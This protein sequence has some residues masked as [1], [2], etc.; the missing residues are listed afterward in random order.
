MSE[1]HRVEKVGRWLDGSLMETRRGKG[2]FSFAEDVE[3]AL[4]KLGGGK[5]YSQD[6]MRA[7][8]V[9]RPKPVAPRA[10]SGRSFG[11]LDM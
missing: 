1:R 5:D 4:R 7:T 2:T 8:R 10:S 6:S 11:R 9:R 3:K